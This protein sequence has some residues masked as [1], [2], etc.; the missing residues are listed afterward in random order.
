MAREDDEWKRTLGLM[1]G[2]QATVTL[3]NLIAAPFLPFLLVHM[4]VHPLAQVE[5][6]TGAIIASNALSS[7]VFSPIWG[8]IG[9]RTGRKAM[10]LRSA[11]AVGAAT[12][13]MGFCTTP[14]ELLGVRILM[15]VFSGFSSSAMALV[16]TQVPK[17]RLGYALGW[18][19]TG[20]IAGQLLGPLVGGLLIDRLHDY[21]TVFLISAVGTAVIATS[22]AAL[23]KERRRERPSTGERRPPAW[24]EMAEILRRPGLAQMFLV[25]LLAQV[26]AVGVSTVLPLYVAQIVGDV[27]WVATASGAAFAITGVAGLASAPFLGRRS[28]RVGYRTVLLISLAGTAI[29]TLPQAFAASLWALIGLRFG[30]GAFL[31]GILP[32]ANA[33][34]GNLARG[35]ERGQVYGMTSTA[36]FLGRFIGPIFAGVVA[37]HF[38]IAAVFIA[39]GGLMLAN[40]I[41]VAMTIAPD[42]RTGDAV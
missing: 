18:L 4:G 22:C 2:V 19:S 31:G 39:I 16:A 10:V 9:D 11:I 38:G 1:V 12:A 30:V 29:F 32:S 42:V 15:G 21:R 40:L 33:A 6:W 28:D 37:A 27:S 34:I 8:A 17:T 24:L 13:L 35:H 20:Q 5:Y 7:A 26:S 3:S 25:I 23:V 36:Q 41:W 14:L